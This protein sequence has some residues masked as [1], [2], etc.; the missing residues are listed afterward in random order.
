MHR[1]NR[2]L[3]LF[4]LTLVVAHPLQAAEKTRATRQ[5]INGPADLALDNR[6][7]LFVMESAGAGNRVF[8]IDLRL[9]TVATVAGNGKQCCYR[10]G[11]KATDV[12]FRFLFSMAIDSMG[13]LF[14]SDG[15]F[16]RKV[17]SR[18]DVISTVAGRE[19]SGDTEDETP[20]LS[21]HFWNIDGLAVDSHG[22]LLIA[23]QRQARIFRLD[24]TTGIIHFYA[25]NG[26]PGFA[27]D[28]GPAT[29]ASF[30]WTGNIAV[31][32]ADNLILADYGNCRI[33]RVDQQTGTVSTVINTVAITDRVGKNCSDNPSSSQPAA[34]PSY[35]AVDSTGN[36]YFVENGFVL[37]FDSKT[38]SASIF[39]GTGHT[40]FSGDGGLAAGAELDGPAG[41]AIDTSGNVFIAEFVN[42][43]VRR[44]DAKTKVIT[45]IAGNGLPHRIDI[46]L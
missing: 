23:D 8:R 5:A 18:T 37:R 6:G 21:A 38:S 36:I 43:R 1:P 24:I 10:E 25:G 3:L 39:A 28:G 15:S 14:L 7:H 34:W 33:R 22:D 35:P 32:A 26:R 19:E 42:N 13:N 41:L 31:D 2:S 16:I 20:A 27:G 29:D 45:T 17:D 4:L 12:G 30:R 46:I 44:V 11:A 9:G 40:G